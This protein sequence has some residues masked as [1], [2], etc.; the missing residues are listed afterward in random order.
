MDNARSQAIWELNLA[1]VHNA[2][3]EKA[4]WRLWEFRNEDRY[5]LVLTERD[6]TL[7]RAIVA[8]DTRQPFPV[9]ELLAIRDQ[10]DEAM[11]DEDSTGPLVDEVFKL[12]VAWQP[13][14]V[15]AIFTARDALAVKS[16]RTGE[17]EVEYQRLCE[18][19]SKLPTARDIRGQEAMDSIRDAARILREKKISV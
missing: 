16:D 3:I 12:Q 10:I 18:E 17:E 19:V 8:G 15:E 11:D 4:A 13:N 9:E 5:V 1:R 7:L 2:A 6:I 14:E